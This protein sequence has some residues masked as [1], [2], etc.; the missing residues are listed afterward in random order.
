MDA[1]QIAPA[2]LA[3]L[4][5]AAG[6]PDHLADAARR[7]CPAALARAADEAHSAAA[8]VDAVRDLFGKLDA[9][10][11]ALAEAGE[12]EDLSWDAAPTLAAWDDLAAAVG[13]RLSASRAGYA[14]NRA[15]LIVSEQ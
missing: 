6:L 11:D 2:D 12:D 3:R 8:V 14:L 13:V 10:L 4:L 9:F 7:G 5:D 1:I 15:A